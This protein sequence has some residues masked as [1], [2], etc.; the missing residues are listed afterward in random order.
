MTG[1][2]VSKVSV[3]TKSGKKK[4]ETAAKKSKRKTVS[5]KRTEKQS[6]LL[7]QINTLQQE[8]EALQDRLLRTL[9]EMDNMKKRLEKERVQWQDMARADLLKVLLPIVDDLERSLKSE[10]TGDEFRQG[11]EMIC[12]KLAKTL[13]DIGVVTIDSVGKPFDVDMHDALLQIE[14]EGV[15]PGLVI[16]EHERGYLYNGRVIRHAK[17]LVSK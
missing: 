14:K 6:E 3:K 13:S 4:T 7:K 1:D 5:A 16:E 11:I 2:S 17:V 10:H 15:A 9:A 8:K 12:Q